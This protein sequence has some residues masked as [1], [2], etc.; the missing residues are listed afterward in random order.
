MWEPLPSCCPL[1]TTLFTQIHSAV[2]FQ[3]YFVHHKVT[4]LHITLWPFVCQYRHH[5]LPT[6]R[7]VTSCMYPCYLKAVLPVWVD[8]LTK[9]ICSFLAR[10]ILPLPSSP[11][12]IPKYRVLYDRCNV[13]SSFI[14][15]IE[16]QISMS[17]KI[18]LG[19]L[20]YLLAFTRTQ[21]AGLFMILLKRIW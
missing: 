13:K 4:L 19:C 14:S 17:N 9:L 3:H 1:I 8:L 7:I 10:W 2:S 16:I 21:S 18:G 5:F 11:H 15:N 6:V 12:R 20:I